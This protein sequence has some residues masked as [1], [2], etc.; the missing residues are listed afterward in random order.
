MTTPVRTLY[1]MLI[2]LAANVDKT[3]FTCI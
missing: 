1:I 3:R 2:Q